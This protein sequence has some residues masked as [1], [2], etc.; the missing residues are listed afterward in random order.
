MEPLVSLRNVW[1]TYP[2]GSNTVHALRD[3]SL[4]IEPAAFISIVGPS[5]SGKSTIANIIGCLDR[6][7]SGQCFI[8]DQDTAELDPNGLAM[9]RRQTVG[10]VFQSFQLLP[11]LS[12]L[13]NV[14]LPL[15]Y[16]GV[17]FRERS[18]RAHIA[19][20]AVRL[21]DRASHLPS[22]LSGGQQQR[23]ALARAI[24]ARPRIIVA[25]EPTAALDQGRANEIMELLSRLNR[26]LGVALVIITHDLKVAMTARQLV[27]IEAGRISSVIDS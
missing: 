15:A 23:V 17:G 1:K 13:G 14:E 10:F 11:R 26:E 4:D 27:H 16:R 12:A 20:D 2:S 25:D 18:T 8:G 24:V 6:P 9:V 3:I 22:Q 7:T 21:R 5:G 19:L